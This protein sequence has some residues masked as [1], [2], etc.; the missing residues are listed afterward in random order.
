MIQ[1]LLGPRQVGKTTAARQ[2]EEKWRGPVIYA[3][4]D[5]P[6]PPE[7]VWIET[8]WNR[9]R[10]AGAGCLLILDEVQKVM[11][12][13]ETVK[14]LWDEDRHKG[15][16]LSVLLLGSSALLLSQG[17]TESLTGRFFLTRC[18]H[19]S[20]PECR[21]AFGWDLDRWTFFGGYPGAVPFVKTEDQWRR[22]VADSLIETVISRDVVAAHR[23]SKPTLLR[24]LF[25]LA[26]RFPSQILSYNKML[27][28]LQDAGNT[29]TLSN[30][31]RMLE[32]AYLL[33]GLERFS[34]GEARSRGSSP[35]FV[36]WNNALVTALGVRSFRSSRDDPAYWGRLVENA[37]GAHFLNELR[38]LPYEVSYWRHR[39]HEVDFV[40]RTPED[41]WG[42]EV[43]SGR[44][45]AVQG[46]TAFRDKY[47]GA[48]TIVIGGSGM[49][50]E[51]FFASSPTDWL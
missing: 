47:P 24:H 40:V 33:S 4:A 31:V 46:L 14:S 28:Q 27:G 10:R 29:T 30:Y 45:D 3:T 13:S 42:I 41:V 21:E 17:T 18:L 16:R 19:W 20:Y 7:P 26:S 43:K 22:Y 2:V 48:R 51:E 15:Q 50:L 49:P 23:V 36:L 6:L 5:A 34:S 11:G 1:I 9:A 8:H 35:K 37:V 38:S 25:V 12:W 39:K 44:P 32:S